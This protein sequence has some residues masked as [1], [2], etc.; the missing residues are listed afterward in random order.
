MLA[1]L[2]QNKN[3]ISNKVPNFS[4]NATLFWRNFE[5]EKVLFLEKNAYVLP[6]HVVEWQPLKYCQP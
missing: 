1:K 2:N 4:S 5:A 6:P 3:P